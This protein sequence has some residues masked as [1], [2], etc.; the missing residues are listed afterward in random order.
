[1]GTRILVGGSFT[2][3]A[4]HGSNA[5]VTRNFVMAFNATTGAI[6]TGFVPNVNGEVESIV[7]GPSPDTAYVSGF[8]GSVNGVTAK[9][10]VLLSTVTGAIVSPFKPASMN[11][12]VY[13]VRYSGNRLYVAGTFTT[14]GGATHQGIVALNPTTGAVDP[15][16]NIQLTGHHN[17]NGVS[18]ANGAVGPRAMDISPDGRTMVIIGNFKKANNLAYDQIVLVDLTGSSAVIDTAWATLQYTAA[19][20]SGAF[21]TYM[22]DVSF[23]PDGSY[24]VISATGAS[25]TNIDGT[26]SLCDTAARWETNATGT[27]VKPTWVDYT[28][29]DSL[30]SVT[31]TGTAIYVGGHQRWLNNPNASDSAGTGAVPRPGLAA[32]DPANGLPLAWNPGRNPRGSGAW[33]SYSTPSGVYI[34]SDTDFFGDHDQFHNQK[35]GFFQLAGGY[36][37]ASTATTALPGNVYFAGALPSSTSLGVRSYDGTTAGSLG[38]QPSSINWSTTRGAFMVGPSIFFGATD[39]NFYQASFN[40]STVGTPVSIDPY[41][42]PNW[43]NVDTGS[44]QTYRGVRSAFYSQ[45]SSVTGAFYDGGRMYYTLSGNSTLFYRYFT[46]DSGIIGGTQF[47]ASGGNFSNV[48]GMFLSGTSLYYANR[49]DGTLHRVNFSG[50]VVSGSDT[51]VNN[52]GI[53]WRAHGLFLN[54]TST[55]PPNQLP[56]ASATSSCTGATCSFDGS[57]SHDPDGTVVSYALDVRRRLDGHRCLAVAHL[58][59]LGYLPGLARGDRQQRRAE[60]EP[61][62]R[63]GHGHREHPARPG[64]LRG[65]GERHRADDLADGHRTGRDPGR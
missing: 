37:P 24:F 44:G 1:M 19:C 57:T 50:G 41:N 27:N 29:N 48:A 52:T 42:D 14:V 8:F 61:V 33:T 20:A 36:V 5:A 40:G 58:R 10:V 63:L 45:I 34:G 25:G 26:R 9:G 49:N 28:G 51:V 38:S 62:D 18:G 43:S 17:F 47:T 7:P 12:A 56:I 21:D 60:R 11:G 35:L 65:Q 16:M 6:D 54:G 46:P 13:A 39:G 3:V 64:L 31:V 32:L 23:S 22:R 59:R 53:D 55:Q 4:P 30:L 2:S 15:F